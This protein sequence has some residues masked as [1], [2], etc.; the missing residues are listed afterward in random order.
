M[1]KRFYRMWISL[2]LCAAC[3]TATLTPIKAAKS[4]R[5][6][7]ET[8]SSSDFANGEI[9]IK[10]SA[11]RNES[12]RNQLFKEAGVTQKDEFDDYYVVEMNKGSDIEDALS[13][14]QNSTYVEK[15]Q[16]NYEYEEANSFYIGTYTSGS[17]AFSQNQWALRNDGTLSFTD[18]YANKEVEAVAG[19]DVNV[20]P[21]WQAV[22][23][24]TS[25]KVIVA[26]IDSGVDV[27][28]PALQG[29]L[30]KNTKEIAGDNIDN[31]DNGYIDDY[32]GWNTYS[33]NNEITDEMSHGT[34]CAGIIAANGTNNV[35]GVTGTSQVIVMPV[36]VFSDAERGKANSCK[37]T[38]FSILRGIKYAEA[39]DAQI[40]NLSLGMKEDDSLL[41][42]YIFSSKMLFVCATGNDGKMLEYRPIYPGC[43]QFNNVISVANVRCDGTLHDSSNYSDTLASI[44]APGTEIYSTL[45]QG[46]YGYLTGTSMATPYVTGIAALLYSY[47]NRMN[48]ESAKKQ[49]CI[50]AKRTADLSGKVSSGLADAYTAYTTDVSAPVIS[51]K[52]TVYKAKGYAKVKL[53]VLDYGIS[54]VK[55]VRWAKGSKAI[56]TFQSGA[57]GNKVSVTGT[58]TIKTTGYYTI[59]AIDNNGNQTVQ[60]IHVTVPVPTSL[61]LNKYSLTLKKGATYTLKTTVSPSGVYAKYTFVSTNKK[62]ATVTSNG[63]IVAKKAGKTTIVVKTQNGKRRTCTVTVK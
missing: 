56:E 63:K 28:Q 33:Y 46:Q 24:K 43:Y 31:D 34:H 53:N 11:I 1:N 35:W 13:C 44:A 25:K 20:E 61:K 58:I 27:S 37:A 4:N 57:S 26:L 9:V 23:S 3:I 12:I 2:V 10:S 15:L 52:T 19:I 45:P 47:T 55:Y 39:N 29:K 7:R 41:Q 36:K 48:A 51:K 50:G 62:V 8:Y 22:S 59:Y 14:L 5:E 21:L 54:G 6:A 49:L 16:P 40:C 30:W 17:I 18:E 38:S 42:E 60:K 32:D